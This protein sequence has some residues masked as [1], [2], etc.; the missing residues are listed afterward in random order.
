MLAWSHC[1]LL[2]PPHRPRHISLSHLDKLLW[3]PS[4]KLGNSYITHSRKKPDSK[5][6]FQVDTMSGTERMERRVE[7]MLLAVLTCREMG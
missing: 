2:D 6:G 3:Y 1:G 5:L 7:P 4:V